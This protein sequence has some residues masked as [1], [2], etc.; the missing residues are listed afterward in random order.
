MRT[1]V[2]A[3]GLACPEPV[4]RAKKALAESDAVTVIVDNEIAVENIRR[5]AAKAACSVLV[6][7]KE[8]GIREISLDKAASAGQSVA[9]GDDDGASP[10][11]GMAPD[12]KVAEPLVVVIADNHM[13]RGDDTLGDI[14][15]R[16][17]VHT[18]TQLKPLPDKVICY[19]GG[20]KLA[21]KDSPACE[22]L[23]QLAQAGV[24]VI[25]CGTCV[26]YFNL[27]GQIGTGR[28]SNMYEILEI[29]AGT[30]RIVRP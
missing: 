22:D 18:L 15:I 1:I 13:G 29:L 6:L 17:F 12:R 2:D 7:E 9:A 8:G 10:A 20:V 30:A 24:D 19:N 23:Q 14:L 28:I 26:Q 25:L 11:C 27:G 5:M 21:G 3:R 16:G 4:L